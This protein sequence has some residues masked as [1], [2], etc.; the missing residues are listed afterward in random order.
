VALNERLPPLLRDPPSGCSAAWAWELV[1]SP[2]DLGHDFLT[3]DVESPLDREGIAV[4]AKLSAVIKALKPP[5]P[6]GDSLGVREQVLSGGRKRPP[7]R[8]FRVM[9]HLVWPVA[10]VIALA[11]IIASLAYLY[12]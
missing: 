10:V 4:Q 5:A 8:R 12:P 6:G 11:A 2:V 9:V 1:R 7:S 3:E